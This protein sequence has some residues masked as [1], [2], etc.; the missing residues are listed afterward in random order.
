VNSSC[1]LFCFA[2][3]GCFCECGSS[4]FGSEQ[5][6]GAQARSVLFKKLS[7]CFAKQTNTSQFF[8]ANLKYFNQLYSLSV[9]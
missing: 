8:I 9:E 5:K 4:C 2:I 1:L 7:S 3:F 6:I